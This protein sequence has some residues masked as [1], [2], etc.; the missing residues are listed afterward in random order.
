MK[1]TDN[2]PSDDWYKAFLKCNDD[3]T[4]QIPQGIS[5]GRVAITSE[6]IEEWFHSTWEYISQQKGGDEALKN[7]RRV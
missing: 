7:Q 3:I 4:Q 2:L 5:T 1:F 6:M